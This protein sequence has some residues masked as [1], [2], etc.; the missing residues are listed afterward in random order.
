VPSASIA[1]SPRRQTGG[2]AWD[3]Q[4]MCSISIKKHNVPSLRITVNPEG[5]VILTEH[6]EIAPAARVTAVEDMPVAN[7]RHLNVLL[8]SHPTRIAR[9]SVSSATG[10]LR[11]VEW[12][13]SEA[14]VYQPTRKDLWDLC[15]LVRVRVPTAHASCQK[16]CDVHDRESQTLGAASSAFASACSDREKESLQLQLSQ[17]REDALALQKKIDQLVAAH[18]GEVQRAADTIATLQE[19]LSSALREVDLTNVCLAQATATL[20]KPK[21]VHSDTGSQTDAVSEYAEQPAL[22]A[23][24]LVPSTNV[25]SGS[26]TS[27]NVEA[28]AAG[29]RLPTT[30]LPPPTKSIQS[31]GVQATPEGSRAGVDI[32][33]G[34]VIVAQLPS[35]LAD[36]SLALWADGDWRP[37]GLHPVPSM[38]R[39]TE[40]VRNVDVDV[41]RVDQLV[42]VLQRANGTLPARDLVPFCE[43]LNDSDLARCW[44]GVFL[45]SVTRFLDV[46]G[47]TARAASAD[48]LFDLWACRSRTTP[49]DAQRYAVS[50]IRRWM[51]SGA[52]T[53]V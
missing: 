12:H 48:L 46:F 39:S 8:A 1:G 32:H 30:H 35:S 21:L 19:R 4:S 18:R 25:L 3:A 15:R 27:S 6:P 50:T 36:M 33:C 24:V 38:Q 44:R 28:D 13:G 26:V 7:Y 41:T 11:T 34:G 22:L 40:N 5:V 42:E 37:P 16:L 31:I 9:I 53:T 17:A 47:C 2:S 23:T 29:C 43:L 45:G 10:V 14:P 20:K 49:D 52:P 51:R